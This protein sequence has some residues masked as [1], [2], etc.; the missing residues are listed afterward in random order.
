MS[1]RIAGEV[2]DKYEREVILHAADLKAL[3]TLKERQAEYN[4]ELQ[5]ALSAKAKAEE[6][7]RG[8]GELIFYSPSIIIVIIKKIIFQ[9][10][11][12]GCQV[13]IIII[14]IIKRLF[15]SRQRQSQK[16]TDIESSL[17]LSSY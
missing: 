7:V 1:F 16:G 5:D 4:T 15:Q 17:F 10:S 6:A 12:S 3:A 2:Q 11:Q 13:I 9:S 8:K 14:I